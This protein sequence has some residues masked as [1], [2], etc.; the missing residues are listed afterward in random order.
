MQSGNGTETRGMTGGLDLHAM[1]N[2]GGKEPE[3]MNQG[4]LI[5]WCLCSPLHSMMPTSHLPW[6]EI[7]IGLG[8]RD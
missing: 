1:H 3:R 2:V 8:V 5:W 7:N 6:H 4:P